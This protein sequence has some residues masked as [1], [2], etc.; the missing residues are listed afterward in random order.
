M[1]NIIFCDIEANIKT[2]KINEIGLVYKFNELK[3]TSIEESCAFILS[4]NTNFIS[5]HNFIDFDL[6]I[7]NETSLYQYIKDFE[8]IDTLP[9]SL[10]LF[11]EKTIHSLP[12]N[13]KSEDDF[14]NNPVEDSKITSIL[15]NKLLERFSDLSQET[16]NIFYSLLHDNI[17]FSAFFEYINSDIKLEKLDFDDLYYLIKSKHNKTIVNFE[18]L[19]EILFTHKVQLSYILALLT[20]YIEIK[21]HPPKILFS[22]PD[23]VEIQKK[24]CFDILSSISAIDE[25]L[26]NKRL[27]SEYLSNKTKRRAVERE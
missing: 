2:K 10:L 12:K 25:H 17:Y 3:T 11:S 14:D 19:K 18:Y 13:Y 24:L 21:S 5:G 8:I 26:E 27:Y 1:K 6:K 23:I 4:C 7:L 9:L 16:K 22:Y 15:F 20:P